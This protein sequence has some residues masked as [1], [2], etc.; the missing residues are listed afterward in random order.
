MKKEIKLT[1]LK[2]AIKFFVKHSSV[3]TEN[4]VDALVIKNYQNIGHRF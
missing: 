3:I 2:K 4:Q 1:Y